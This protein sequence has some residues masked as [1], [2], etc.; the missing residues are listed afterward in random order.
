MIPISIIYLIND[1]RR[2]NVGDDDIVEIETSSRS[3]A[4]GLGV[5]TN[6][7]L[8][9]DNFALSSRHTETLAERSNR[10]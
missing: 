3:R 6:E 9:R 10:T 7:T 1:Y 4:D 8:A 5:L 2:L